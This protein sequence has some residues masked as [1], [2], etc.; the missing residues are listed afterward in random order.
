MTIPK[1]IDE[2]F[3]LGQRSDQ[4]KFVINDTVHVISGKHKG[5]ESAV[6]SINTIAP[7]VTYIL[8]NLDGSGDII[9]SQNAMKLII[10]SDVGDKTLINKMIKVHLVQHAHQ[11]DENNIDIKIIGI[12]STA[13]QAQEAI[14]RLVKQPGFN[15]TP[16]SFYIDEYV[17]NEDYWE[18]GYVP[19]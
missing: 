16:N 2:A 7:D 12:Y 13:K 3:Y 1:E 6:I 9:I 18:E 19:K 10:P 14:Q 4:V 11:L 8:E 5:K 17:L 15:E